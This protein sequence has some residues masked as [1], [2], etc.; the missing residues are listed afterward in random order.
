MMNLLKIL[1]NQTLRH[2]V[3]LRAYSVI[4]FLSLATGFFTL[5]IIGMYLH[6][7]MTYDHF[8]ND[9]RSIYRVGLEFNMTGETELW[10]KSNP[11]VAAKLAAI[12]EVESVI[13]LTRLSRSIT[14]LAKQNRVMS[15]AVST[16]VSDSNFFYFFTFD[17]LHPSAFQQPLRANE[18]VITENLAEELFE[19]QAAAVGQSN[20]D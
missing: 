5:L 11:F 9:Y 3:R 17:I 15:S 8:H 2:V 18:V 19:D 16:V 12:E 7:E 4:G 6:N 1:V 13:R 14:T 20:F 10:P